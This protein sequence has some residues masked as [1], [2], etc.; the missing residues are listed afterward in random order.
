[1]TYQAVYYRDPVGREPVGEFID[2]LE[3][4]CQSEVDWRIGLLNRLSDA[5]PELPFPHSS[6][7]RGARYRGLRE[8]RAP[9]GRAHYRI[10]FRRSGRFF[11]LLH[12][13]EKRSRP[14]ASH[15]LD[16]AIERWVDFQDRMD[17]LP[18]IRPRAMGHDAP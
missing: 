1:V 15:D 9:C 3:P 16:V 17:A 7:I 8:L 13:F 10:L 11:I 12:A 4:D 6:A 5:M 2:R 18:R 14:I